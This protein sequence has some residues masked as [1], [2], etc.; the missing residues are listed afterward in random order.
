ME[1]I[2]HLK[3]HSNQV[4]VG[5]KVV[6]YSHKAQIARVCWENSEGNETFN[7]LEKAAIRLELDWGNDQ[8]SKVYAHDEGKVWHRLSNFN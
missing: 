3:N 8:K 7:E 2:F 6:V 1:K 5:E 4:Q